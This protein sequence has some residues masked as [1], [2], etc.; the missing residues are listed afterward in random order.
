MAK[1]SDP[2]QAAKDAIDALFGDTSVEPGETLRRLEDVSEHI[3]EKM[4]AINSDLDDEM[5]EGDDEED[6]DDEDEDEEDE[7]D[8]E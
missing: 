2:V 6:E 5:D 4:E 7:E 1:K 3:N 8:E